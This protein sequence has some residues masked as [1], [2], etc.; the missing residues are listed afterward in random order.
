V[1]GTDLGLLCVVVI[2]AGLGLFVVMCFVVAISDLI[3]QKASAGHIF[4]LV[5]NPLG[6]LLLLFLGAM[7]IFD[8]KK[9][10]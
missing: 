3:D 2:L 6:W 9:R 8:G 1:T 10:Q 5:S 4:I 7:S